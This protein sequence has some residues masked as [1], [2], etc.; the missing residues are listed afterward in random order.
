VWTEIGE[1][2]ITYTMF[3]N[4]KVRIIRKQD[5]VRRTLWLTAI[6][7]MVLAAMA[8]QVWFSAQQ[9][10]PKQ[11]ADPAS[12]LSAGETRS[13]SLPTEINQP[14]IIQHSVQQQPGSLAG[15]GQIP[16]KPARPVVVNKLQTVPPIA[17]TPSAQPVLSSPETATVVKEGTSNPSF[18]EVNQVAPSAGA[19]P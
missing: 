2:E 18:A 16:S 10:E 6:G 15:T 9:A 11:S 3:G 12:V 4:A 8:W 5:K 17:A 14:A 13:A 1:A 7:G 19:Q